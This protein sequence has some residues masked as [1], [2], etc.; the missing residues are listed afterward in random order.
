MSNH[1][2]KPGDT[3]IV[4]TS[5]EVV[6]IKAIEAA[7]E[8]YFKQVAL[9]NRPVAHREN[10]IVHVSDTFYLEELESESDAMRKKYRSF[11]ELYKNQADGI[12]VDMSVGASN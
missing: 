12:A 2:F 8:G 9:V 4:R 6:F 5:G 10:G 11:E 3:A 7:P 1:N